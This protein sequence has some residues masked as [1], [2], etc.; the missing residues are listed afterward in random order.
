MEQEQLQTTNTK[1]TP[2]QPN[3]PM[4]KFSKKISGLK[5]QITNSS[6]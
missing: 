4:K 5:S 6:L 3:S 1:K 2:S